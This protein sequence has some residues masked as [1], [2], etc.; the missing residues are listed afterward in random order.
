MMVI[1]TLILLRMVMLDYE[2]IGAIT[3]IKDGQEHI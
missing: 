3:R 1:G 2:T